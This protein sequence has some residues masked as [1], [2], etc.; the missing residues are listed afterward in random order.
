MQADFFI[1]VLQPI[2][3]ISL[4]FS[5]VNRWGVGGGGWGE[6]R[7][8]EVTEKKKTPVHP[9]TELGLLRMSLQ[10]AQVISLILSNCS[11]WYL[12]FKS[13]IQHAIKDI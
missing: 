13:Q 8:R 12:F 10:C 6:E 4:I 9:Q 5:R 11:C 1:L 7:E 2:K 3:I